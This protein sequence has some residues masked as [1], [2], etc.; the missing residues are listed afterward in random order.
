M[1]KYLNIREGSKSSGETTSSPISQSLY[2]RVLANAK[3]QQNGFNTRNSN[4]RYSTITRTNSKTTDGKAEEKES[5]TFTRNKPQY[6]TITRN[7]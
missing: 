2:Q 7:R 5:R 1:E 6:S 3:K 4:S